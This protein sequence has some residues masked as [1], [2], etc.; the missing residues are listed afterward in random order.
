MSGVTTRIDFIYFV[1]SGLILGAIIL[2]LPFLAAFLLLGL[3]IT[4]AF[5]KKPLGALAV[6]ILILPFSNAIL[7][8]DPVMMKGT[9]PIYLIAAMVIFFAMINI[10]DSVKMPR[11]ALLIV[12]IILTV[13][14]IA[15]L[16][17]IPNLDFINLRNTMDGREALSKS[18]HIL[19]TLIRPLFYFAPL[20]VVIKFTRNEKNLEFLIKTINFAI[21]IFS[22]CILYIYFFKVFGK[23]ILEI[24]QNYSDYIGLQRN[25][26]ADYLILGLPFL[27]AR[28]F[29]KRNFLNILGIGMC[30]L[31]IGFSFTRT[32]YVTTIFSFIFYFIISKR[33]KFLPVLIAI[34]FGATFFV[35]GIII[36]RAGKGLDTGDRNKISAGR[37]DNQWIPLLEEYFDEPQKLLLGNG[38]FA[39]ASSRAVAQGLTPDSMLHPHNMYI[40][41]II[42]AG[43]IAFIIII[44]CHTVIMLKIFRSLKAAITKGILEYQYAV[45]VSMTSYFIAGITGRTLFPSGRSSLLWVVLGLGIAITRII[46]ESTEEEI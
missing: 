17:S 5:A 46:D 43:I 14:I 7:L 3:I 40:E 8:R 36:E 45:F 21:L 11:Y 32:A 10:K 24:T 34:A 42:D 19:K 12:L 29:L 26:L 23:S 1:F 6:M 2:K 20:V 30:V 22:V 4:I 18:Q 9:E 31:A 28:Y 15:A 37:I 41:Q 35:S 33:A 16:R 39:I 25:D 44:I 27:I 13:F 38:R